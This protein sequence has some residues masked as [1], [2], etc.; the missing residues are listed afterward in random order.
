MDQLLRYQA[1]ITPIRF[2]FCVL[3]WTFQ[4]FNSLHSFNQ[5]I[6]HEV[7]AIVFTTKLS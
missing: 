3:Y 6:R 5:S 7:Q 4:S 2:I 1:A